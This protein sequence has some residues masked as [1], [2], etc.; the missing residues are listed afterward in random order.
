MAEPPKCP[1]PKCTGRGEPMP[2]GPARRHDLDRRIT[3]YKCPQCG[4]EIT[5]RAS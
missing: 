3:R 1:T 2:P 4:H 5:K